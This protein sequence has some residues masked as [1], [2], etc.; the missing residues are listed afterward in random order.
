[1]TIACGFMLAAGRIHTVCQAILIFII[2]AEEPLLGAVPVTL[3]VVE[4]VVV[5]VAEVVGD[6]EAVEDVEA[7]E[8]VEDVED[9]ED[10]S[11]NLTYVNC[12]P[13]NIEKKPKKHCLKITIVHEIKMIVSQHETGMSLYTYSRFTTKIYCQ[14]LSLLT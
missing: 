4:Q 13:R 11:M 9:V 5:V 1:M 8:V 2:P 6:A 12:D 14:N 3:E 10:R 7:V